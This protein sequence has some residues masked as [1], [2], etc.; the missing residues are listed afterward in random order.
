[1]NVIASEDHLDTVLDTVS[2][3]IGVMRLSRRYQVQTV[4][5]AIST[6]GAICPITVFESLR[7]AEA[8]DILRSLKPRYPTFRT[9]NS[10]RHCATSLP[11]ETRSRARRN[12]L[13]FEALAQ[14]CS[15]QRAC[16]STTNIPPCCRA[17]RSGSSPRASPSHPG[18]FYA[19]S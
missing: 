14:S 5:E 17:L 18:R 1:V 16:R 9:H 15:T 10:T 19:A 12:G 13:N 7:V 4:R 6:P 11:A 2:H 8:Y 3:D